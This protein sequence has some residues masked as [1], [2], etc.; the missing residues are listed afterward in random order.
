ME[1]LIFFGLVEVGLTAMCI[2]SGDGGKSRKDKHQEK[3]NRENDEVLSSEM[4]KEN[5][6]FWNLEMLNVMENMENLDVP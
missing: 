2:E 1:K 3:G 5:E 4:E 6:H